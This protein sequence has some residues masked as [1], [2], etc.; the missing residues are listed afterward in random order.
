ML[1][2]Y[3]L[4]YYRYYF[5]CSYD[6]SLNYYR[7]YRGEN[8]Q[9]WFAN[10]LKMLAEY[11]EPKYDENTPIQYINYNDLAMNKKK[12]HICNEEFSNTD[13]I[14]LDHSHFTGRVRGLA[15]KSCNLNYKENR[16]VSVVFH[17][18]SNY[19]A[20]F[21]IKNIAL[22]I[23]GNI[24][25]LPINKEK[26]ISFVKSIHK[27][28]I[29]FKFI[30]SFRFLPTSL[31]KLVSYCTD[32]EI[33]KYEYPN[34]FE[35]LMRKGIFPY[36]YIDSFNKLSE[37]KLPEKK[38]FYS[39]LNDSHISDN[40]YQHA[41]NV[42]GKFNIKSI[43][44]YSDLYLKTDVLLL[45]EVFEKFRSSSLHS[46]S[47][48]PA[49]Y[50]TTP[51][52]SW[53]AMMLYTKIRL[54]LIT[55]I[56]MLLFIEKG[57]RGGISQCSGRYSKANNE[58]MN[59]Y[60]PLEEKKYLLY[61]DANNLYGWA[62]SQ[63]L[64]TGNFK[65]CDQIDV[66]NIP[67]DSSTG[68]IFEVDLEYPQFLHDSHSDFPFAPTPMKPPGSK[69][70]KLLL[71]ELPKEKYII[72]YRNL[73]QCMNNGLVLTKVH[74]I[75]SFDQS[76]WLKRYID[77]NTQY[78]AN[79]KNEFEKN[80]YKLMNNAVFGKT[81]ENVRKHVDVKLISHWSGRYGASAMIAKPNFHS[82]TIF[83]E[84][85]IAVQLTKTEIL[86]NKPIY[87]GQAI[88]DLSKVCMYDFHYGYIKKKLSN[89]E[90][91]CL[92]TDTDSMIYEFIDFNPYDEMI[93]KDSHLFDTSD[94]QPNNSF[95]IK[96][97]NKKVIGLMKDELNGKIMTEF[98]GLRP[99]MYSFR[100][101]GEDHTNK[102]KGV[103]DYVTKKYITFDDYLNCLNNSKI[104][105]KQ[106]NSIRSKNHN[107][108]SIR[109]NKIALSPYDDK[110]HLLNNSVD[111][112][113]YGHYS[114]KTKKE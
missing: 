31:E 8:C 14:V 42:W 22:E 104:L 36:E 77:L 46:H 64:P 106:Q 3:Y 16:N 47:L 69:H 101:C 54:E 50:F 37:N 18:L 28:T 95:N 68:Y 80:F 67:D 29:K 89:I 26:Y 20:H 63:F 110:R 5:M 113:P 70:S 98:I 43:G 11:I 34:N 15:H 61:L 12:C 57:I 53:D 2:T 23:D 83:D 59:D 90:C 13:V 32:F 45:A 81:M 84:N 78:R 27:S 48:D 108:Y 55:D 7:A 97:L 25:L 1:K 21:I 82:R 60:N 65:W 52:L 87:I 72:H 6:P 114:I 99:K 49:H 40:D 103:K 85:L 56:D 102:A 86:M 17:N 24:N 19:D 33:I 35:L 96:L 30:D 93:S 9:S 41:I 66:M 73:K 4:I 109:Q 79:S 71:T 44:E 100:V 62:M 58:Y 92:Y 91:K 75:L 94:Y 88:L 107:V 74:R 39:N 51:G 76:S 10:E 112:L 111:T 38:H 105:I